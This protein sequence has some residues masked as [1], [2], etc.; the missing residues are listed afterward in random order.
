VQEIGSGK[1]FCEDIGD[2]FGGSNSHDCEFTVGNKF[3]DQVVFHLDM[4]DLWVPHLV[5]GEVT[6]GIVVAV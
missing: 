3:L 2:V 1:W 4:F 5:F 6:G